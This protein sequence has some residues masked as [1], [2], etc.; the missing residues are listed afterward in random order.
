MDS[1]LKFII[2]IVVCQLAGVFGSIF[3]VS[4][5]GSWYMGLNKPSFN[6]PSWVFGPVWIT[7]YVM[8]GIALFLVWNMDP[9]TEGRKTALILFGVQLVL[10]ALWS[11]LFFGAQSP[12]LGLIGIVVL[13]G[14]IIATTV[15]F[16]KVNKVAAYLMIPYILWVSFAS[17]LNFAIWRLN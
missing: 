8:M 16:C 6:P 12:L 1:K 5:V 7:L 4:S 14:F 11:Y 10:N 3:T 17:V 15:L 13:L 9:S 2:A